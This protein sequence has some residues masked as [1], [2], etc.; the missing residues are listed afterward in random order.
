V[1]HLLVSIKI[2]KEFLFVNLLNSGHVE[3]RGDASLILKWILRETGR[4]AVNWTEVVHS[5]VQWQVSLLPMLNLKVVWLELVIACSSL[6][7][8]VIHTKNRTKNW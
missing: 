5:P 8:Y 3:D 4:E 2:H 1:T 6:R 7:L